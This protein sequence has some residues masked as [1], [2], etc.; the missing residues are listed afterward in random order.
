MKT[1]LLFLVLALS[2][3][4][5]AQRKV[6]KKTKHYTIF[7]SCDSIKMNETGQLKFRVKLAKG[8]KFQK[9]YDH[10]IKNLKIEGLKIKD[11][12]IKVANGQDN[13][14]DDV[15]VFDYT[16]KRTAKEVSIMGDEVGHHVNGHALDWMSQEQLAGITDDV[17]YGHFQFNFSIVPMDGDE[18]PQ[19]IS[20]D[21]TI[22]DRYTSGSW[23]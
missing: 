14:P 2:F 6:L 15:L 18:G 10:S 12:E 17:E 3:N 7:V 11:F 19:T 9:G 5:H 20:Q 4:S 23:P 21:I 13:Y 22:I 16:V 1:I 8:H